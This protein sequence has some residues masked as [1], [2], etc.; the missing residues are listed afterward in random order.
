MISKGSFR[1]RNGKSGK[2]HKMDQK[3]NGKILK[4]QQRKIQENF[5]GLTYE[6]ISGKP[7]L[8]HSLEKLKYELELFPELPKYYQRDGTTKISKNF[9]E[10]IMRLEIIGFLNCLVVD[11]ENERKNK[12]RFDVFPFPEF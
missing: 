11:M 3:F 2:I 5:Q 12:T 4:H 6:N 10:E 8:K 7:Q 1:V 9:M